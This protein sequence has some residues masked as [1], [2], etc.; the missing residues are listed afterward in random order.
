[1]RRQNLWFRFVVPWIGFALLWAEFS[2]RFDM[3]GPYSQRLLLGLAGGFIASGLSYLV[4]P[5]L[6]G[7]MMKYF[8]RRSRVSPPPNEELKPTAS[9]SSLVE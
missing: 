7:L 2:P 6:F 1:M 9:P 8:E 4:N 5:R 3:P